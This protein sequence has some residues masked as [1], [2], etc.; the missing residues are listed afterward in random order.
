MVSRVNCGLNY[1]IPRLAK[2][3]LSS[4]VSGGI[5][6]Q[7][8]PFIRFFSSKTLPYIKPEFV[9][10]S[11]CPLFLILLFLSWTKSIYLQVFDVDNNPPRPVSSKILNFI[12]CLVWIRFFASFSFTESALLCSKHPSWKWHLDSYAI[13]RY[14]L[15]KAELNRTIFE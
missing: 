7:S 12:L 3:S 5:H 11:L 15:A 1:L 13:A 14:L 9:S 10:H 2:T 8:C 6:C 4:S